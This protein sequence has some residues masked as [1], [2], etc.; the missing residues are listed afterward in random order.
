MT[1]VVITGLQIRVLLYVGALT[2]GI[3]EGMATLESAV[4]AAVGSK[5]HRGHFAGRVT[6][7]NLM[8]DTLVTLLQKEACLQC[9]DGE[10]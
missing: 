3:L 2:Y 8:R 1:F 9:V 4:V 10:S 7:Q 6:Q 5:E